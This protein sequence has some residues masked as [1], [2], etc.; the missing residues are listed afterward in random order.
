MVT[1]ICN[2]GTLSPLVAS[3]RF[4]DIAFSP[5]ARD[6]LSGADAELLAAVTLTYYEPHSTAPTTMNGQQTWRVRDTIALVVDPDG[7]V[8]R[9]T[10]RELP[11]PEDMTPPPLPDRSPAGRRVRGH[12]GGANVPT[13]SVEFLARCTAAG[14][15]VEETDKGTH[16]KI[17]DPRGRHTGSVFISSTTNPREIKESVGHVRRRLGVDIR[18]WT[19]TGPSTGSAPG[20]RRRSVDTGAY[21]PPKLVL[22]T[23]PTRAEAAARAWV[24]VPDPTPDEE[25]AAMLAT[26]ERIADTTADMPDTAADMPDTAADTAADIVDKTPEQDL[27]ETLRMA[28]LGLA[29]PHRVSAVEKNNKILP[30]VWAARAAGMRDYAIAKALGVSTGSLGA[31][32][33]L[34]RAAG[35]PL[36]PPVLPT[37]GSSPQRARKVLSTRPDQVEAVDKWLA[38]KGEPDV[39][40]PVVE[41]ERDGLDTMLDEV[42]ASPEA[43]AAFTAARA[44]PEP[45]LVLIP[46]PG[47]IPSGFVEEIVESEP[48]V[49]KRPKIAADDD[50]VERLRALGIGPLP[51]EPEPEDDGS[52]YGALRERGEAVLAELA[53]RTETRLTETLDA[54]AALEADTV[55]R[56]DAAVEQVRAREDADRAGLDEILAGMRELRAEQTPALFSPFESLLA[57]LREAD[58]TITGPQL[59]LA[60]SILRDMGYALRLDGTI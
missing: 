38:E 21:L 26:A 44:R 59:R 9:V 7:T 3:G 49:E 11:D 2:A 51:P 41:P 15:A 58:V 57:A 16:W 33:C 47:S 46:E 1:A 28:K 13:D 23:G 29:M 32:L 34:A 6:D 55:A 37:G 24:R 48:E 36:A 12:R 60:Q 50:E 25:V 27:D 45:D 54:Y 22:S 35:H 14:L 42:T 39:V 52:T 17:T 8:A 40:E 19:R 30:Y 5:A 18:K 4:V 43:A 20:Q 56:L 10:E 31:R 53:E